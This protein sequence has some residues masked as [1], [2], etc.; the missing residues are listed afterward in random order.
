MDRRRPGLGMRLVDAGSMVLE[1][2]TVAHAAAMFV[3]LSDPA[4]YEYENEP[5]ASLEWLTTRF[6]KLETRR[7]AD[8]SEHWLNW[9]VRLPS[10]ALAGYV[11]ATVRPDGQAAIAYVFSS[12]YWGRGIAHQAVAAMLAELARHHGVRHFV[13]VLK[14]D[15]FRSSRLLERL[16]FVRGT[17]A[18]H[19]AREVEPDEWLMWCQHPHPYEPHAPAEGSHS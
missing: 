11:Q 5:P 2:Q 6:A 13:A 9:V 3:V 15:N 8:G 19:E 4:I 17:L 16:G 14:R 7:S 1:P 18:Q 10:S 12:E